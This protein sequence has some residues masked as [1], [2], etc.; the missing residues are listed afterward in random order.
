MKKNFVIDTNVLIEDT[1]AI[2]ILRNGEEN[3][4][5]V[6]WVVLNELDGLKKN[7]RLKTR[8]IQAIKELLKYKDQIKIVNFENSP[9]NIIRKNYNAQIDSLSSDEKIL[10]TVIELNNSLDNNVIFVTNDEML[11][12]RAHAM[13]INAE[14][15]KR[16]I[17]FE[18]E[19]QK[20]NGFI[21]ITKDELINNCFYFNKNGK[22]ELYF[23]KNN[24]IE[25]K[26]VEQHSIWK[27]EPRTLYQNAAFELL[28]DDDIPL[29]TIQSAAGFGKTYI[30]LAV[31]LYSLLEVKKYKKIFIVKPNID[32]G[33]EKLGFLP[34]DVKDKVWPYFRPI[35]DLL[36]K[37]HELRPANSIWVDPKETILELNP[38]KVEFMPI[39]FIRGMNI[40]DSFVIVDEIQG[41][42][43]YATRSLLSRMGKNVKCVCLGDIKQI[44]D[45]NL[46]EENNGLNWIV[47]L[48]KGNKK[49]RTYRLKRNR[50]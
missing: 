37:L 40:E 9:F 47:S 18:V 2:K 6:P 35:Y 21:D 3:N 25:D 43:R 24:K 19:S 10:L 14:M 36:I 41:L 16:S 11:L 31:A 12:L 44:D 4:I 20:Y 48:C 38:R 45:P 46:T 32:V 49:Y 15:Y 8:S 29:V 34:G 7:S 33:S 28:L 42:S 27:V 5:Y 22:N 13:G 50:I 1:E 26:L 23:H 39:N 30:S 17:P